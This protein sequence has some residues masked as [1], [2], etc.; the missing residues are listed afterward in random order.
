[1]KKKM[2]VKTLLLPGPVRTKG[3]VWSMTNEIQGIDI[4][5][6]VYV[7]SEEPALRAT[8]PAIPKGCTPR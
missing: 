3:F 7:G 6:I 2:Y 5:K 4:R 1:M 8:D